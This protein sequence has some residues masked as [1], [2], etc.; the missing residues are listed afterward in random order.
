MPHTTRISLLQAFTAASKHAATKRIAY[1]K[2][3]LA[4]ETTQ[5]IILFSTILGLLLI[6][7][8]LDAIF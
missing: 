2:A 6:A 4:N 3:M 5:K 1:V 8:N 7:A